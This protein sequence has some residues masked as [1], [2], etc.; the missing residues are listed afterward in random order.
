MI[1]LNTPADPLPSRGPS[2]GIRLVL[3]LVASI[4]LM[5]L[6]HR[7]SHLKT[8][9]G[10]LSVVVY[11]IQLVVDLPF[12]IWDWVSENMATR[13]YLLADN[14]ALRNNQL[15]IA[16]RLQRFEILE[17]E[18]ARL[19][20]LMESAARVP[21]RTDMAEIM[22]LDLDPYRHRVTI[23]KGAHHGIYQ[24]QAMLDANGIVGQVTEAGLMTS[25]AILISDPEHAL[26]VEVNR[27]GLRTIAVGTG[28]VGV[29][30]LPFLPNN[31]DI[32]EG[33]L[34]VSSG[35]GGAF[36]QGYPVAIVVSVVRQPGQPF[37]R[38]E[39]EPSAALNQNREILLVWRSTEP[40]PETGVTV[41]SEQ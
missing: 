18:N 9:R 40:V 11:P 21:N 25:E 6:D 37:A 24:G 8:L 41:G 14:E 31:A 34:L 28:N 16:P 15:A 35:L 29:L 20:A 7:E 33:D 5:V 10:A 38:I 4:L 1:G 26:P 39:A 27:N 17:A 13:R 19:R 2:L 22:S 30:Q 36:P 3:L 23:N 32:T 12:S